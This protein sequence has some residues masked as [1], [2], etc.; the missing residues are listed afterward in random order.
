MLMF[1]LSQINQWEPSQSGPGTSMLHMAV[2]IVQLQGR[3]LFVNIF[4][5]LNTC[6]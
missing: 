4:A 2:K 6:F 5:V 1:K 3:D